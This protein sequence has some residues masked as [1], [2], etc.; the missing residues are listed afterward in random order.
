MEKSTTHRLY[1]HHRVDRSITLHSPPCLLFSGDLVA[2]H[3]K[4]H[5]FDI[6]IPGKITFKVRG[7]DDS[8]VTTLTLNAGE[9]D[10]DR[11]KLS[12]PFRYRWDCLQSIFNSNSSIVYPRLCTD[13][14][15]NLLRRSFSRTGDDECS[16]RM[17]GTDLS[18]CF[19]SYDRTPPLGTPPTSAVSHLS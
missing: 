7:P 5:L 17:P 15:G 18:W 6:D 11:W 12:E 3:R 1:T 4:V 16:S 9:R 8:P 10:V 19:Q 13:W 2:I 14:I